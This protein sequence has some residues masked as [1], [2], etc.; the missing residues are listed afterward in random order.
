M[1]T[2]QEFYTALR[3]EHEERE[4]FD[5]IVKNSDYEIIR[6]N[7]DLVQQLG[8]KDYLNLVCFKGDK[9][10]WVAEFPGGNDPKWPGY[11]VVTG[12]RSSPSRA[13]K[14]LVFT[15]GGN[16]YDVDIAT[17]EFEYVGWFR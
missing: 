14:V 17:G 15:W 10:L 3:E 8:G 4:G 5:D 11:N 13:D 2:N 12:V 7:P 16:K 6:F 9:L 1:K